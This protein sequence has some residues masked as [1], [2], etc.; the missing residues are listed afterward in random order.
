METNVA[1][2]V[3]SAVRRERSDKYVMLYVQFL[4]CTSTWPG[5]VMQERDETQKGLRQSA[6]YVGTRFKPQREFML[7]A[8]RFEIPLLLGRGNFH[9][10]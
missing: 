9:P 5:H 6:G 10:S 1:F 7:S 4:A 8:N 3:Q 2:R